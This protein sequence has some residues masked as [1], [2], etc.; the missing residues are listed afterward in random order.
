MSEQDLRPPLCAD[1]TRPDEHNAPAEHRREGH[2]HAGH[3]HAGHSHAVSA[4]ADRRYLWIALFLLTGFLIGEVIVALAIGSLVLL[5]DAGHMLTDAASIAAALW[6]MRLA[7]RPATT[8]WTFGLK[9]AEILSACAN[10][11]TLIVVGLIIAV[12]AVRRLFAPPDV[13]G[14]GVLVVAI[15]GVVVN[16]A[17][18]AVLARANRSS[19]NVEGA[20]QHVLTD[21]YAFIGTAV[22]GVII[23]L[24]G[25]DRADSIA[26][27]LVVALML[28]SGWRLVRE[29]GRILLQGTPAELDLADVQSHL[30]SVDHVREV[31]DLHAWTVTSGLP[32]LSAHVVVDDECFTDGHS[33]ALLCQLQRCLVGHFDVEH[34]T[35]QLEP[36]GHRTH[37]TGT[38]SCP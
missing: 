13:E 36:A 31:H 17:A 2:S 20:F 29:S 37:E 1:V 10:G 5:A 12:E 8:R 3:S 19:L 26:S 30:L 32:S 7:A 22:A 14:V 33:A 4:D 28:I 27:L 34:S 15:I 11:V 21:L 35:F 38:H 18:T 24:T 6:A 23:L 25:F 16:V 9:R